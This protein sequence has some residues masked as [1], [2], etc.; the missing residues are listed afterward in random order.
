M[1]I[2]RLINTALSVAVISIG[3]SSGGA[4]FASDQVL[5]LVWS[6]GTAGD[7]ERKI[8]IPEFEK[9]TGAKVDMKAS[10]LALLAQLE[11]MVKVGATIWDVAEL[12]GGKLDIA[13]EKGL[14]EPIDYGIVDPANKLPEVARHKYGVVWGTYS[15]VLVQNTAKT[16]QGKVM[17]SWKDFWDVK[18]FPG[19]R[20][21][22]A[23]PRENLEYALLADGVEKEKIYE[24]LATDEGVERALKKLSELKPHIPVWW[25]N[26]AQSVQ[27]LAD[28]EVY[29]TTTFNGR[30]G[31]LIEE[32]TPAKIVW[33]G[34]AL[35]LAYMG[36]PKGAKNKKLAHEYIKLRTTNPELGRAYLDLIPYPS[37]AP[38][39]LDGLPE[40]TVSSLPASPKNTEM[41]FISNTEFWKNNNDRIQ[42][43]WNE[44]ML[45]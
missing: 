13:A 23:W 16:P 44:W 8:F 36:I 11:S 32:G 38:G 25:E 17:Q 45:E 2:K 21:L 26:G 10:E 28:G 27:L 14:L 24:I 31:K 34:G 4:A 12:A 15:T 37:F 9:Q 7:A 35:H 20:S 6:G 5:S 42:E 30:V 41:Q 29:Y 1:K 22:R 18:T 39:L 19:P 43:R 33:N 3:A 40:S